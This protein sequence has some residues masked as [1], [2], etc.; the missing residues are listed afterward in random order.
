M[1]ECL[2]A[3]SCPT[4]LPH[5]LKPARLLCPWDFPSKNTG[6]GCHFLLQGIFHAPGI[7]PA[8]PVSPAWAGRFFTTEPWGNLTLYASSF[9]NLGLTTPH[10]LQ[11]LHI[12][13]SI[14]W[15]APTWSRICPP[16][17]GLPTESVPT[18]VYN[19]PLTSTKLL[20]SWPHTC[21]ATSINPTAKPGSKID[22]APRPYTCMSQLFPS[23][24]NLCDQVHF[25]SS[26]PAPFPHPPPYWRGLRCQ[27]PRELISKP[28][29]AEIS[30]S[31]PECPIHH[32]P[33]QAQ[34][35]RIERELMQTGTPS[36]PA[37]LDF[38]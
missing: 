22:A 16:C 20:C 5:R 2:V 13:S 15:S 30:T 12:I 38:I 31:F 4:L 10:P 25:P 33:H 9:Q 8:S 6:V 26:S 28:N 19:S 3:Q 21:S 17:L 7:E 32:A 34:K 24:A 36:A 11:Y 37:A 14:C 29:Q 18:A 23:G 27:D 35:P 1:C